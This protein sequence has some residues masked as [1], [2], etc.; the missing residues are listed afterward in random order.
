MDSLYIILLALILLVIIPWIKRRRRLAAVKHILNQKKQKKENSIMKEL[1]QR[2][3]GKECLIYTI[4]SDNNSVNGTIKEITDN[5][6]LVE[7][8]GYLQ[9][10]N[11]EFVT[12]IR[13]WPRNSKGKK[14]QI[15]D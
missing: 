8:D 2:F 15:F 6:I 12:R 5:G 10:V 9:V 14:K 11:L 13:E 4:A 1:A 7:K 3:I